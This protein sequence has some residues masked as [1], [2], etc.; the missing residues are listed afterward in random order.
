MRQHFDSFRVFALS[1]CGLTSVYPDYIHRFPRPY[2]EFFL[3]RI[4]FL[5]SPGSNRFLFLA[6]LPG[7]AFR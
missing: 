3:P 5:H 7:I 1:I 6:W 2:P 4:H